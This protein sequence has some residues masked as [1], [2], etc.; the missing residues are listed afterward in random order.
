MDSTSRESRELLEGWLGLVDVGVAAVRRLFAEVIKERSVAG[1]VEQADLAVAVG[2]ERGL[3]AAQRHRGELQH[4]PA[5]LHGLFLQPGQGDDRVDETHVQ[6]LP[7][8]V[9]A[10]EEPDLTGLLLADDAG[11]IG[12]SEAAIE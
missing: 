4:L 8:V 6:R 3:H 7:G 1:E 5:P 2:I 10:A 9:L 12:R 11:K